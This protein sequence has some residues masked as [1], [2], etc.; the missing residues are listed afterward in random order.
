MILSEDNLLFFKSIK[1]KKKSDT[2]SSE[3]KEVGSGES[4]TNETSSINK[5][6]EKKENLIKQPSAIKDTQKDV[7]KVTKDETVSNTDISD[8]TEVINKGDNTEEQNNHSEN[9]SNQPNESC[10]KKNT[11]SN[12]SKTYT[13]GKDEIKD[14][15]ETTKNVELKEEIKA[16]VETAKNVETKEKK[17]DSSDVVSKTK[18]DTN[19]S[20]MEQQ[21]N[22]VE[23][24]SIKRKKKSDT[25]SSEKKE[26]GSG[27][28]RTNET[29]SINKG[30]EKKENLIKQP[31]A[32]KDTQKDVEK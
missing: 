28:S 21:G 31:S 16:E 12:E 6:Q 14:E 29:S 8:K 22:R 11:D 26:V 18:E 1:R 5:G 24:A 10:K 27:E 20:R 7:E 13:E 19:K 30:Q 3:K 17:E 4:R 9:K 25:V 23:Y 2:V 15:V 32:I